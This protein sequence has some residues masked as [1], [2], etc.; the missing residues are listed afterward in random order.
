MPV[1]VPLP[2]PPP[3]IDIGSPPPPDPITVDPVT[4]IDTTNCGNC[5]DKTFR[6]RVKCT[7]CGD[8]GIGCLA[9]HWL[10]ICPTWASITSNN[11]LGITDDWC[12]TLS[13]AN[14]GNAACDLKLNGMRGRSSSMAWPILGGANFCLSFLMTDASTAGYTKCTWV[15]AFGDCNGTAWGL[16]FPTDPNGTYLTNCSSCSIAHGAAGIDLWLGDVL[17]CTGPAVNNVVVTC[18]PPQIT[19][20]FVLYDGFGNVSGSVDFTIVPT[21]LEGCGGGAGSGAC[22]DDELSA[23]P[24]LSAVLSGTDTKI[25]TVGTYAAVYSG[26]TWDFGGTGLGNRASWQLSCPEI[27]GVANSW[28]AHIIIVG[29]IP[30]EEY[31]MH[32]IGTC[33]PASVLFSADFGRG[34]VNLS[35]SL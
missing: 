28:L 31:Y 18:D 33:N 29:A 20:T 27:A 15:A 19:G 4:I 26:G 25:V 21:P 6:V 24:P 17:A 7:P 16:L 30:F 5:Q 14:T 34:P 32:G 11:C 12:L 22:C 8:C 2:P 9:T 35:V 13:N 1:S 23:H 10:D 3:P